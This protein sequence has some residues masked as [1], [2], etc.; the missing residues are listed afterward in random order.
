MVCI[1]FYCIGFMGHFF[2]IYYIKEHLGYTL[3]KYCRS[4]YIFITVIFLS[5]RE[6]TLSGLMPQIDIISMCMNYVNVTFWQ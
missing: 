6:Q 1:W 5:G 2:G 3:L 4:Q